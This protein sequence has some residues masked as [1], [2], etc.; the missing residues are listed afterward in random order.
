VW[1]EL[2][3][4]GVKP[5][6]HRRLTSA[7][8]LDARVEV[9]PL[10]PFERGDAQVHELASQLVA[11]SADPHPGERWWV[12]RVERP[13]EAIHLA[14]LMQ[15]KGLVVGSHTTGSAIRTL[16]LQARATPYRNLTTKPWDGRHVVGRAASYEGVLV[17]PPSSNI[18]T[19]RRTPE[20]RWGKPPDLARL[21]E[22]QSR[23]LDVAAQGVRPSGLLVY[24]VPTLTVE[25]TRGVVAAFL[26]RHPEFRLKPFAHPLQD[27]PT[28]GTLAIWPQHA[29]TEAGFVARF[30]R[31]SQ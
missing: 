28:D 12:P 14:A 22:D 25:E 17:T 24:S 10:A 8:R 9:A 4:L 27:E 15:G 26:E 16:T 29:D 19:W 5:W 23:M 30:A 1:S 11:H 3:A 20:A 21:T 31:A 13:Q 6:I 7:A 18:G 2:R